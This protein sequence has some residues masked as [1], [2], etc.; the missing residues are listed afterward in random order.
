MKKN[1][2]TLTIGAFLVIIFGFMLFTF[3]VRETEVAILGASL[4]PTRW[5]RPT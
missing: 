1:Y 4:F 2:I 3:Q 5:W